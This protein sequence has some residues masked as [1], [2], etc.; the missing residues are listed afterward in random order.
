MEAI[1]TIIKQMKTSMCQRNPATT[2]TISNKSTDIQKPPL[3]MEECH[4]K[5]LLRVDN[6]QNAEDITP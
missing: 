5:P 3:A 6:N 2:G 1:M 4:E